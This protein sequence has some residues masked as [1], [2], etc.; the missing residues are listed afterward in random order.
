[1]TSSLPFSP[2]RRTLLVAG[3]CAPLLAGCALP[4]G[5][6]VVTPARLAA[7]EKAAGGRLGVAA[8]DTG[9]GRQLGHRAG[10]RF[11]MCSTFKAIASAAILAHGKNVPGLLEQRIRY[12]KAD[13][14]TYSPITEQ[15]L[16]K[17]MTVAELCEATI[18]YSDN[19]A[20]NLLMKLI[21]GP[22]G[23]TAFAR[24]VG[25]TT[26]RLDRWETELN[27]AIPGDPRDTTTPEAMATLLRRVA[28][29]DGLPPAQRDLLQ[30]WMRGNTTGATRIRAGVPAGWAVADKTGTGAYGS[31]NDIGI[32]FPPKGAPV[33]LALYYT[34]AAQDAKANSEI[35][36]AAT[37][38]VMEELGRV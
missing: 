5:P 21:G 26:F 16:D 1:M 30:A 19:A 24:S 22:A 34:Q 20:A 17:G 28:L 37:R 8:V 13:L 10:E 14:V 33:V 3:A 27:S 36:A 23:V 4:S 2:R 32:V 15:E 18:Q 31:S 9:N 38:V 35:L 12:T 7:L 6:V 11:P 29:D 25:D